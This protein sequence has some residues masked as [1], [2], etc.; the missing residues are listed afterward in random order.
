[1][2]SYDEPN[3][4]ESLLQKVSEY[5]ETRA[6]LL[7]LTTVERASELISSL[8]ANAVVTLIAFVSLLLFS[9]AAALLLGELLGR[10]SYGF[11]DLSWKSIVQCP[12]HSRIP[13]LIEQ[14]DHDS[15][16]LD[17]VGLQC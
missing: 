8:A 1:M 15:G 16:V 14:F 2:S 6:E 17:S 11:R 9:I 4:V 12:G 7:K 3:V 10:Y 13:G 5:A